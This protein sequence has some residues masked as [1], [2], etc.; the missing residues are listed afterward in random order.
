MKISRVYGSVAVIL[1]YVCM[2]QH[3]ARCGS[4]ECTSAYLSVLCSDFLI[5]SLYVFDTF[6]VVYG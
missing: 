5:D 4:P 1:M 2:Y 6:S 3:F